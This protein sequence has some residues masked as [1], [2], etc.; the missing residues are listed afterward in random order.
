MKSQTRFNLHFSNGPGCYIALMCGSVISV[1]IF[2]NYYTSAIHNLNRFVFH[3]QFS[4]H[5]Q[6]NITMLNN[7]EIPSR[8]KCISFLDF[9][10]F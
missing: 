1:Y 4:F 5:I 7:N 6:E 9:E 2:D 10:L 8:S 3:V